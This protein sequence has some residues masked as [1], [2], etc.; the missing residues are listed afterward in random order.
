MPERVRGVVIDKSGSSVAGDRLFLLGFR[1]QGQARAFTFNFRHDTSVVKVAT[2]LRSGGDFTVQLP[3]GL[4][5]VACW[6]D[7]A[8]AS[9][10]YFNLP[11]AADNDVFTVRA[12]AP[13]SAG[14]IVG[15]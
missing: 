6:D 5:Y 8:Q 4:W 11:V 7:P 9:N 14:I 13:G 3:P 2:R 12:L 10:G 1:T 15:F